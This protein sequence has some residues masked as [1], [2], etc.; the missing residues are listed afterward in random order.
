M[1]V[2]QIAREAFIAG[3]VNGG[4]PCEGGEI[5]PDIAKSI[6]LAFEGWW[7]NNSDR[8]LGRVGRRRKG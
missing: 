8:F 3:A 1:T 7:C 6:D 4:D 2:K 5:R